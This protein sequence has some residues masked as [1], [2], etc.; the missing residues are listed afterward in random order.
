MIKRISNCYEGHYCGQILTLHVNEAADDY[1]HGFDFKW[2]YPTNK[3]E[4]SDDWVI[5]AKHLN[6]SFP[7]TET[8]YIDYCKLSA[9]KRQE[10]RSREYNRKDGEIMKGVAEN[11]EKMDFSNFMPDSLFESLSGTSYIDPWVNKI[12][13]I[14]TNETSIDGFEQRSFA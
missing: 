9:S 1:D 7:A 6:D 13:R 3:F 4:M 2:A 12:E 8:E 11:M 5:N 14:F 10:L